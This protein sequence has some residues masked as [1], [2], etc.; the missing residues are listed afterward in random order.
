MNKLLINF[1]KLVDNDN[2]DDDYSI[3]DIEEE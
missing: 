1:S 2:G 3:S